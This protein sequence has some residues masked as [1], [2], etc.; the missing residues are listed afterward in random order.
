MNNNIPQYGLRTTYANNRV[1]YTDYSSKARLEISLEIGDSDFKKFKFLFQE[2]ITE[3]DGSKKEKDR[4]EMYFEPT[5]LL[6]ELIPLV[7][8]GRMRK[9]ATEHLKLAIK[10]LSENKVAAPLV[11]FSKNGGTRDK[12]GAG[13]A[14]YREVKLERSNLNDHYW[15]SSDPKEKA[16]SKQVKYV[17]QAVKA[18]GIVKEQGNGGQILIVPK[19]DKNK[20]MTNMTRVSFPLTEKQINAIVNS[21]LIE[22][23]AYRTSQYVV[24]EISRQLL[25]LSEKIDQLSALEQNSDSQLVKNDSTDTHEKTEVSE[26]NKPK[27]EASK[28]NDEVVMQKSDNIDQL[29]DISIDLDIDADDL[30]F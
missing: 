12:R 22:L 23:H 18:D 17:L 25:L 28:P 19:L 29:D 2:L 5:D 1:F 30:P 27:P 3:R 13:V 20:R 6:G 7:K 9:I 8:S 10:A 24:V 4:I 11:L 26:I 14:E 21:I 15:N 16:K